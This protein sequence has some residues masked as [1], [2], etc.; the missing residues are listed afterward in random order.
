LKNT[1]QARASGLY[2]FTTLEISPKNRSSSSSLG[3]AQTDPYISALVKSKAILVLRVESSRRNALAND[4]G[5]LGHTVGNTE[6]RALDEAGCSLCNPNTKI[7]VTM[8]DSKDR[9]IEHILDTRAD[10]CEEANRIPYKV[11]GEKHPVQLSPHFLSIM[12]YDPRL[13]FAY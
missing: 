11:G 6:N 12:I 13:E 1:A 7:R 10:V 2:T 5:N 8:D 3:Y 4:T 9:V